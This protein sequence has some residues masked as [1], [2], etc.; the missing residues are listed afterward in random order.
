MYSTK[1]LSAV[2]VAM[3]T[4]LAQTY[5]KCNPL[6]STC[7]ADPALGKTVTVDFT[8]GE[9]DQFTLS[10]TPAV[11]YDSS[12]AHFTVAGSGDAP[13]LI[14]KWYMMFGHVDIVLQTAPGTG[15]VS[16]MVLQSDDL[17]EIDLEW[18]GGDDT[19]MQSNYFGKGDTTT[20]NRGAFHPNPSNHDSFHTYSV[21]WTADQIVWSI[22]N[23]AVRALTPST[24]AANQYPQTP[25]H[26]KLG[27]WAGGDS[28]NAPGTIQWAGGPVDYAAGPYTML[29]KSV[30]AVD[31]STGT[32]YSYDGT[33]GN[34]QSI[35]STGGSV[36]SSSGSDGTSMSSVA[37]AAPSATDV[38]SGAPLPFDGTHKDSTSTFSTPSIWPWVASATTLQS[39]AVQTSIPGLPSG[40]TVSA[41]GKVVPP[42]SAPVS[43]P[44]LFALIPFQHPQPQDSSHCARCLEQVLI[45]YT[46]DVPTRLALFLVCA[47][48]AGAVLGSGNWL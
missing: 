25:M 14:S 21:D 37:A 26:L 38:S 45:W 1:Y 20:Y 33:S 27:V 6:D 36:G 47:S 32:E 18:L 22:D 12:G 15:I 9:S 2:A 35:K 13:T 31:Y 10:G 40:W 34:W 39:S 7:P 29:V 28:S 44:R 41:S 42:S 43:E 19:Q 46:V 24:A 16:T 3:T 8:S 23:N 4:V 30:K 48:I 17:D 11:T 5:T